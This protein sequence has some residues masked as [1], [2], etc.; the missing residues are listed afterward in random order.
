ME[1]TPTKTLRKKITFW[2]KFL[3]ELQEQAYWSGDQKIEDLIKGCKRKVSEYTKAVRTLKR[4]G[5]E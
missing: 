2:K 3:I 1:E 5:F 4:N